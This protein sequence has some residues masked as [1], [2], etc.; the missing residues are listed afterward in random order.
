[1]LN[2]IGFCELLVG[3]LLKRQ[4]AICSLCH[5]EVIAEQGLNKSAIEE[6]LWYLF[7]TNVK[8]RES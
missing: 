7:I 6:Y 3:Y 2:I 5:S 8:E 1:M 4:S